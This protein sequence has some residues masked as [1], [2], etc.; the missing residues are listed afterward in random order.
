MFLN[1]QH[2]WGIVV[3][4]FSKTKHLSNSTAYG[5]KTLLS[6]NWSRRFCCYTCI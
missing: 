3:A 6:V 2:S 1:T 4:K 5:F